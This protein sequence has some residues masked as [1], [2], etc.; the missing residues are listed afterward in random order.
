MSA[1]RPAPAPVLM[2]IAAGSIIVGLVD[3]LP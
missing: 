2:T 1:A 3:A